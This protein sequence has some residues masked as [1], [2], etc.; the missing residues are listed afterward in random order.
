MPFLRNNFENKYSELFDKLEKS[1]MAVGWLRFLSDELFRTICNLYPIFM[2]EAFK[3]SLINKRV[4]SKM[5]WIEM[6]PSQ[7]RQGTKRKN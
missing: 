2:I 1:K 7:P 6:W 3:L 5:F 4:R